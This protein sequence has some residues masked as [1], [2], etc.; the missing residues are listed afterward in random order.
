MSIR[1]S[2]NRAIKTLPGLATRPTPAL[3]RE[4]LFNIWQGRLLGCRWL[5][6]CSGSGAMGAEA[7]CRGAA[8]V[9]GIEQSAAACRLIAENW[10]RLANPGQE[11]KIL[12]GEVC[13]K[14]RWL[15]KTPMEIPGFDYIYFDPPYVSDL[16]LPVL[17]TIAQS[18]LLTPIGEMAVEFN[19]SIPP[20]WAK[21]GLVL[22][23]VKTYGSTA[24]G[25]CQLP[26]LG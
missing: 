19:P 24:L 4:A 21:T 25:F 15:Q 5:D 7:L 16:Y 12:R 13:Q 1:I 10:Q 23:R 8:V 3:V 20:D 2:G 6:L 22:T 14:L 26:R 9:V 17:Q 11:F 18:Q